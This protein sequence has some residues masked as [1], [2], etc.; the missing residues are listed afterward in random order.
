MSE[1]TL[2]R[3]W[4]RFVL[5]QSRLRTALL[6]IRPPPTLPGSTRPE[7]EVLAHLLAA[8]P[9]DNPIAQFQWNSQAFFV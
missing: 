6:A 8:F 2:Q 3:I 4:R 7:A 1:R 9:N 5:G